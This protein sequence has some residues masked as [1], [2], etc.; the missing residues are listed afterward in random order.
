M[1]NEHKKVE[2][3]FVKFNIFL[4]S[5]FIKVEEARYISWLLLKVD[6]LQ[7]SNLYT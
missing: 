2:A 1:F 7:K 6:L 3:L 4:F 5:L